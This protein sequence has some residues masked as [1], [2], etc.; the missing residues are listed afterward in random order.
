MGG[1]C[2][3]SEL[4]WVNSCEAM[5]RHFGCE[6]GCGHQVGLE[7]PAY[8]TS[9][10]LDTYRQCLVTDIAF[11]TCDAKYLKTARLCRCIMP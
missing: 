1:A 3:K 9:P 11:S 4:E 6:A 7:L 10:D 2:S 8:A 5:Q